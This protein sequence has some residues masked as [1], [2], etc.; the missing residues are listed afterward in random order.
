MD[1]AHVENV[2]YY[3]QIWHSF[4]FV[5]FL[6]LFAAFSMTLVGVWCAARLLSYQDVCLCWYV[7]LYHLHTSFDAS[8]TCSVMQFAGTT[9]P[10][11]HC[12]IR[13]ISQPLPNTQ[14]EGLN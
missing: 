6:L 1:I 13:L 11:P 7:F 4:I 3:K 10:S 14:M 9:P 2:S 5:V 8:P 12:W